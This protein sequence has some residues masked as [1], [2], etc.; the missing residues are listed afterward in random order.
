MPEV[1]SIYERGVERA[2]PVSKHRRRQL[3]GVRGVG[4]DGMLG[5]GKGK[6]GV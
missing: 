1:M 4:G 6:N 5:E 2:A 3:V